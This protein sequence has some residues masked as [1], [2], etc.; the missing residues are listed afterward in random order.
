M[1]MKKT[2]LKIILFLSLVFIFDNLFAINFNEAREATSKIWEVSIAKKTW[3]MEAQIGNISGNIFK[4]LKIAIW[5]LLVIYIVYAWVMMI[6]SMWDDEKQLSSAKRSIWYA[7]VW[8]LFINIPWTLYRSFSDKRTAD[9][10]TWSY[11]NVTTIY[12]RNIFMNSDYF[13]ATLGAII[14]FLEIS[15]V[16]LAIFVFV[17][18]WIKIMISGWE[19]KNISEA[20]NKILWS[21][22]WLIFIWIMEVW[23]NIIFIWDFKWA[24]QD[25]FS[26]LANLALF[27]AWPI[28]IFF[29]SLAWYYYITAGGE[30]EKVKKAKNI[31]INTALS[32]L[33]L[34]WMYTFLLDLRTLNF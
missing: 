13:W 4:T 26:K 2:F 9:D 11:W 28:A 34:L 21:L 1:I 3:S 30:E 18:N 33:I 32:T 17:Y 16:A 8:L 19:D 31:I 15:I 24:G 25:M 6:I 10:V 12:E 29:I 20:K 5:W 22:A 7:I 14:T 27:F 23:R